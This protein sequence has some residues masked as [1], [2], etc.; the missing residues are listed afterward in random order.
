M[1]LC[2]IS[3]VTGSISLVSGSASWVPGCPSYDARECFLDIRGHYLGAREEDFE[4]VFGLRYYRRWIQFLCYF[5]EWHKHHGLKV[6]LVR[7][8]NKKFKVLLV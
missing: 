4:E 8:K 7:N 5:Y 6:V 2:R 1:V 3:C